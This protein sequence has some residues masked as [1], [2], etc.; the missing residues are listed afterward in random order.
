MNSY[1]FCRNFRVLFTGCYI[2]IFA[3]TY[4]KYEKILNSKTHSK[5]KIMDLCSSW[6]LNSIYVL[7]WILKLVK[8]LP[9]HKIKSLKLNLAW[10]LTQSKLSVNISSCCYSILP[11]FPLSTN[12][13]M[14]NTIV[15]PSQQTL[16]LLLLRFY[17]FKDWRCKDFM[18]QMPAK[19]A[20]QPRLG[21]R[22]FFY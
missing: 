5:H 16:W 2:V 7:S 4:L 17:I 6:I 8:A 3:Y 14:S 1:S 12:L 9:I 20:R 21:S 18:G 11:G 10:C 22:G 19:L 13:F 15:S